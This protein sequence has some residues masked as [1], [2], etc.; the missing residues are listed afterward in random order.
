MNVKNRFNSLSEILIGERTAQATEQR[1]YIGTILIMIVMIL[2]VAL[3]NYLF[4][5]DARVN[6]AVF[7][8]AI[9]SLSVL[10]YLARFRNYYPVGYLLIAILIFTS[11]TWVVNGGAHGTIPVLYMVT[12]LAMIGVA[13]PKYHYLLFTV[14]FLHLVIMLLLEQYVIGDFIVPYPN[15]QAHY[16]D[17]IFTYGASMLI[18]FWIL[19]FYKQAY[20][21]ETEKLENQKKE[22][23][24]NI[25]LKNMY[26]TIMVH[27]LKGSFNNIL[28]FSDLM[29]TNKKTMSPEEM[30]RLAKLTNLS[31]SQSYDLLEDIFEWSR[32][33]QDTF[34][35]KHNKID[36]G[37]NV[38]AILKKLS[39]NFKAK[40]L[41]IQ[42]NIALENWVNSDNY[43]INTML[44]NLIGNAIKFTPRHGTITLNCW[45][46]SQDELGIS[47]NDTGIGMD[48][49]LIQNLFKLDYNTKRQGTE[50]ELSNGIGLK[51]CKEL[52]L[53]NGSQLFVESTK[54]KGTTLT[55]TVRKYS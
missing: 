10:Y 53:K 27:D 8:F 46:Y 48:E 49:Q 22:L 51:I 23:E 29:D 30:S 6:Y 43:Y 44:R 15:E 28:G 41:E 40:E 42:N 34:Q 24:K 50:G 31:A 45:N 33:Q 20:I 3:S 14:F 37:K 9:P 47:I 18:V 38:A 17:M 4:G 5:L 55:F 26:F 7:F 2:P 13:K 54:D 39:L 1:L 12:S 25:A 19:R 11:L 16:Q 35:L 32:I 52:T 36:L 21:N